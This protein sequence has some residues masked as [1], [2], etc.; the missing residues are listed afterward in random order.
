MINVIILVG[1]PGSRKSTWAMEFVT[2]D[3]AN[4]MRINNDSFRVMASGGLNNKKH[5]EVIRQTRLAMITAAAG[6]KLNLVIDNVNLNKTAWSDTVEAVRLANVDAKVYEKIFFV[7][8]EQALEDNAKRIGPARL[9]DKIIKQWWKISGGEKL[10][11]RTPKEEIL[12]VNKGLVAKP[13]KWKDNLP[14]AIMVDLDGTL[15]LFEHHR[16]PYDATNCHLDLP[17]R[18]VAN[19]VK[20]ALKNG[21][22]IIFCSGREDKF[23]GATRQFL[24]THLP[25]LTSFSLHMRKTGDSRNDAII[26]TEIFNNLIRDKYNVDFVLDDRD[27]VVQ[28]FRNLGLTVFQ[29]APGNF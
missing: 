11:K 17:N 8:L 4:W 13:L 6:K 2:K 10:E 25:E 7:P 22:H 21:Y 12:T 20:L 26:K 24:T 18:P 3:P 27:R 29:V 9:D 28:A 1:I 23:E 15:A 5:D 16:G 19:A 14:T